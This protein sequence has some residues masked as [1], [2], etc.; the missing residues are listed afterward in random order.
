M[1]A[2]SKVTLDRLV[3]DALV[4]NDGNAWINGLF[5]RMST[6]S[7][8]PPTSSSGPAAPQKKKQFLYATKEAETIAEEIHRR[9]HLFRSHLQL[10]SSSRL[11]EDDDST[12]AVVQEFEDSLLR[13]STSHTRSSGDDSPRSRS[14]SGGSSPLAPALRLNAR[15]RECVTFAQD[16]LNGQLSPQDDPTITPK[17][18]AAMARHSSVAVVGAEGP[19]L[20]HVIVTA[21]EQF[22]A[23]SGSAMVT[24]SAPRLTHRR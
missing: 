1:Q 22:K 12:A 16:F 18:I 9:L 13:L 2:P 6:S 15:L 4:L 20:H 23:R 19:V 24:C 5:P 10:L 7:R 8:T 17:D 3:I 14:L 21:V 11:I